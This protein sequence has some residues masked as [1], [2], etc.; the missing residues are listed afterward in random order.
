MMGLLQVNAPEAA[1]KNKETAPLPVAVRL[2]HSV[3][4]FLSLR[5]PSCRYFFA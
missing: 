1:R 5:Q 4:F 2:P 3:Y